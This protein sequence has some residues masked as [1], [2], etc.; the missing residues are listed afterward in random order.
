MFQD[1]PP[2]YII[3]A[4]GTFSCGRALQHNDLASHTT[5]V[6][7]V[8]FLCS[9]VAGPTVGFVQEIF[10]DKVFVRNVLDH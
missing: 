1:T 8:N 4:E 7:C 10:G 3:F 5:Y 9:L 2:F 6:A